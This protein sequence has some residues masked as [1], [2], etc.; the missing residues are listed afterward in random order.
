[1][2]YRSGNFPLIISIPHGGD[3][4]PTSLPDR[5]PGCKDTSN[6]CVYPGTQPCLD[7]RVCSI[8]T[9]VDSFPNI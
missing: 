5:Q 2:E 1:M 7:G 3:Q 4:R 8:R 6:T 9:G